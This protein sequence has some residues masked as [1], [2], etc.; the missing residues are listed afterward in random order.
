[1]LSAALILQSREKRGQTRK[2][3]VYGSGKMLP[4]SIDAGARLD[5]APVGRPYRLDFSWIWVAVQPNTAKQKSKLVITPVLGS[6][7]IE[8]SQTDVPHPS[9]SQE[10]S[11]PALTIRVTHWSKTSGETAIFCV[12]PSIRH[13]RRSAQMLWT[14][15]NLCEGVPIL[16]WNFEYSHVG[17]RLRWWN[18]VTL[19]TK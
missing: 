14:A 8:P 12:F 2:G 4:P 9:K 13:L 7:A 10:C 19:Q 17:L 11:L 3:V 6:W 1:M 5:G 18:Q 15:P 16:I